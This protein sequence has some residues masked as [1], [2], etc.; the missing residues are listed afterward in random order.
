MFNIE[1]LRQFSRVTV[2]TLFN[3]LKQF[4]VDRMGLFTKHWFKGRGRKSRLTQK[5]RD[6]LYKMI[7]ADSQD[8]GFSC[9]GRNTAMINELIKKKFD[10]SYKERYL[11]TQLKKLG[12]T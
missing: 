12:L 10:V 6:E 1:Y 3:W 2:R 11:P 9:G 4:M 5:E 7:K 8:N